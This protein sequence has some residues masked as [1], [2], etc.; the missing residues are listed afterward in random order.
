MI[1]KKEWYNKSPD[2]IQNHYDKVLSVFKKTIEKDDAK[3]LEKFIEESDIQDRLHLLVSAI[4]SQDLSTIDR[5][6]V[7]QAKKDLDIQPSQFIDWEELKD[8]YKDNKEKLSALGALQAGLDIAGFEPTIGSFADGANAI[9]YAMRSTKAL[10]TGE[11][12]QAKEHMLDAGISAVS[13]IPFAD[14]IKILR[15]RKIPKVATTG[16]KGARSLKNYAKTEKV[17]RIKGKTG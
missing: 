11:W 13:L 17:K 1:N 4:D 5:A 16:I 12:K 8:I 10:L 15:L 14:V 9:I 2:L 3:N 6:I 7:E